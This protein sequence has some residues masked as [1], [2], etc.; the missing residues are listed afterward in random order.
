MTI[1]RTIVRFDFVGSKCV[2]DMVYNYAGTDGISGFTGQ[3]K[4]LRNQA[5]QTLNE[6]YKLEEI[7]FREEGDGAYLIFDKVDDAHNFAQHLLCNEKFWPF[8]IGAATGEITQDKGKEFV[9]NPIAIAQRLEAYGA[10][11]GCFCIDAATYTALSPDLQQKYSQ[12]S[13]RGKD[14]DNE[15]IIGWYCEMIAKDNLIFP[16]QHNTKISPDTGLTLL[17]FLDY[18]PNEEYFKKL[19]G[20]QE[21]AFLIQA[22]NLRIQNWLIERLIYNIP[23]SVHTNPYLINF[24]SYALQSGVEYFWHEF[25]NIS[26]IQNPTFSSIIKDL[27]ISCQDKTIIIIMRKL[28]FLDQAT[29]NKIFEFWDSLV[30]EV[31]SIKNR[32]LQSRLVLLMVAE[33][34]E[35]KNKFCTSESKFNFIQLSQGKISKMI[36]GKNTQSKDIFLLSPG[37]RISSHEIQDWLQ[38]NEVLSCLNFNTFDRNRL[39]NEVIP[40][41][42][43]VP[44][45]VLINICESVFNFTNGI[46]EIEAKWKW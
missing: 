10:Y 28:N 37:D 33:P 30:N 44:E 43:D 6:Q 24:Q 35:Y 23:N 27:A 16:N 17:R 42:S 32:Q 19:I 46:A 36:K 11:P 5:L 7:I 1:T 41:W 22:S 39:L 26:T 12:K 13:V 15:E 21:V 9:G 4:Y 20:L 29:I 2:T 38:T 34:K 3:I 25:K 31:R 14:S 18:R 40:R 45:N 8:R